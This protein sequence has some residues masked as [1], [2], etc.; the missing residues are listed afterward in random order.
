VWSQFSQLKALPF[1]RSTKTFD[2]G[3]IQTSYVTATPL[4]ANISTSS[5]D[6]QDG[7]GIVWI[8]QP[9]SFPGTKGKTPQL[10]KA[11]DANDI[12]VELWNSQQNLTRDSAGYFM[13]FAVPTINNGKVYLA[14]GSG[15]INVY[16]II[17]S[18][19]KQPDCMGSTILSAKKPAFASSFISNNFSPVRAIDQ[20]INTKWST[21]IS[22]VQW[23]GV[24]LG[25]I[26]SICNISLEWDEAASGK[27]F[28]L[29]VSNDSISWTTI[30]S[31]SGNTYSTNSINTKASGKYVRIYCKAGNSANGYAL[32]ELT[33]YGSVIYSCKTPQ[34]II[35]TMIDTNSAVVRW[36][37]T[38]GASGYSVDFKPKSS[39]VWQTYGSAYDS[40]FCQWFGL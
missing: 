14:N 2:L 23:I 13:K 17:D 1:N 12:T 9:D 40:F 29:Q 38:P 5:N 33:V 4:S 25:S 20:D 16:G 6:Y 8:S 3:K 27:N 36:K 7:T 19:P 28:L 11:L 35:V 31:V 34:G 32:K 21:N 30:K 22:G 26:D 39:S 24:N 37:S 10:L 15:H 18:V